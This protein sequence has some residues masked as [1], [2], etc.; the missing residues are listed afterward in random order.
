[1]ALEA[2][3]DE[4]SNL[5]VA[6]RG[7]APNEELNNGS[8]VIAVANHYLTITEGEDAVLLKRDSLTNFASLWVDPEVYGEEQWGNESFTYDADT[9][10]E[11]GWK[12]VLTIDLEKI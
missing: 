3:S 4:N 7:D 5:Y 12:Q 2:W 1:M 11:Q 9:G 6:P 10:R 8:Q